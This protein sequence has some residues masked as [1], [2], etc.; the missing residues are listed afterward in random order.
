[1]LVVICVTYPSISDKADQ[2]QFQIPIFDAYY[3]I[4]QYQYH[5]MDR[6]SVFS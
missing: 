6:F 3:Y 5:F 2:K 1:M 4:S